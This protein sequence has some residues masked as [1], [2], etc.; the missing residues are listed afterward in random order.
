MHN[1]DAGGMTWQEYDAR[2]GRFN[3]MAEPSR[4][5]APGAESWSE[6]LARV[7]RC[8]E[9]LACQYASRTVVMVTHA[10][11]MVASVLELLAVQN[12]GDRATLD[13]G[14][15]SITT[16]SRISNRWRLDCFND[17]G[18]LVG[19]DVRSGGIQA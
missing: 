1:G 12:V 4:A 14:Y 13:P 5:F 11:F 16:W 8:L 18:H 15:T 10:G 17:V 19:T 3:M 9:E 2:Y 7:R 6:V